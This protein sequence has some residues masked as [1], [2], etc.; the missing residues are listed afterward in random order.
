[1]GVQRR[2]VAHVVA[3]AAAGKR[4][5]DLVVQVCA[6]ALAGAA[7]S[8][9]ASTDQRAAEILDGC[10][11]KRK[12]GL[13]RLGD[14]SPN[15]LDAEQ[16]FERLYK[17]MDRCRA[18]DP[19]TYD[20]SLCAPSKYE[21]HPISE[22]PLFDWVKQVQGFFGCGGFCKDAPLLFGSHHL[23]D[24]LSK[25]DACGLRIADHL[26]SVGFVLSI[27]CFGFAGIVSAAV[28]ALLL[29]RAAQVR[30]RMVE[31]SDSDDEG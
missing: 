6:A 19:L 4:F 13:F 9:Y 3:L 5:G 1:V 8:T 11:S 12:N 29:D 7:A 28:F 2:E 31:S 22:D 15:V 18:E 24:T 16:A 26:R 30:V 20:L 10:S 21:L 17:A 27:L 23:Q 14:V 25:K